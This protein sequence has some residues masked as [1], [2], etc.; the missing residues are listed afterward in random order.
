VGS[1][2]PFFCIFGLTK[3]QKMTNNS[4]I[5]IEPV[6]TNSEQ[7]NFRQVVPG[8][9]N[10]DLL[11]HNPEPFVL[12]S[13]ENRLAT[14]KDRYKKSV[15]QSMQKKA[16]PI[17]EGVVNLKDVT[18][19][20]MTKLKELGIILESEFGM[21]CFQIHIHADEGHWQDGEGDKPKAERDPAK[22]KPNYHAHMVFDFTHED[23]GKGLRLKPKDFV[24]MQTI[25]AETLGM[26]RGESSDKEHLHHLQ[27][28][29]QQELLRNKK[30]QK[31]IELLEQKKN[32][33]RARIRGIAGRGETGSKEALRREI[34]EKAV[35]PSTNIQEFSQWSENDLNSAINSLENEV[36][37]IEA[38]IQKS[39]RT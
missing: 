38:E 8:Y 27:Y 14:I 31:D 16:T 29:N 34:F 37:R 30:L 5:H 28:K 6:K 10:E 35:N 23:T 17:R 36:S 9:V 3:A 18:P 2:K 21:R 12:D 22:W 20:T 13:I 39:S 25:V 32:E 26:V 7:H 33:V 15:G 11:E 19:Q 1:A 24:L 4:S